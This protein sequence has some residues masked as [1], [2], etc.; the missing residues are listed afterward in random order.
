MSLGLPDGAGGGGKWAHQVSDVIWN[1]DGQRGYLRLD[2][3]HRGLRGILS[4][5][6]LSRQ[7]CESDLDVRAGESESAPSR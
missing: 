6:L 1:V 2:C 3:F 7:D 5:L 4:L